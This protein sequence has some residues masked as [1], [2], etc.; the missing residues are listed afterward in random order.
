[1]ITEK[2]SRFQQYVSHK[3]FIYINLSVIVAKTKS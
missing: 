1:M 2:E 3:G